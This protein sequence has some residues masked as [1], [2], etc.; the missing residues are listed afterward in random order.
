MAYSESSLSAGCDAGCAT[1]AAPT[2]H[3]DWSASV[4]VMPV[5][6]AMTRAAQ[7]ASPA[8]TVLTA[9][10]APPAARDL[11]AVREQGGSVRAIGDG[12]HARVVE[13]WHEGV[14]AL[15]DMNRSTRSM[16]PAGKGSA[17]AALTAR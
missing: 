11:L 1:A 8:P 12:D 7:K 15:V 14:F 4:G 10:V 5:W 16:R 6:S 2:E 9:L 3:A 13:F 17:S